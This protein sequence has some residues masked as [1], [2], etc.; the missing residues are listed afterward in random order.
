MNSAGLALAKKI[1]H[2]LDG[3][4]TS[5]STEGKGSTFTIQLP[6]AAHSSVFNSIK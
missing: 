4:V 5:S 2:Q 1:I 3:E 6:L